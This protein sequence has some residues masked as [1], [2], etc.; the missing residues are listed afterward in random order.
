MSNENVHPAFKGILDSISGENNLPKKIKIGDEVGSN[1]GFAKVTD[2]EM[3]SL[4]ATF[5][6]DNDNIVMEEVWIC[7]KSRCVFGLDN[8][9][10]AWGSQIIVIEQP[11]IETNE[12]TER[13]TGPLS[14][15]FKDAAGR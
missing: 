12:P 13:P 4:D 8:G 2:I 9:H 15:L 10:W 7:D 1:H 3:I 14:K 11:K 5:P 6:D